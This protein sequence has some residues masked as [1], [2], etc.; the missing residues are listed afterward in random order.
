MQ[1][2]D[3]NAGFEQNPAP[4][5]QKGRN[6]AALVLSI[7]SLATGIFSVGFCWAGYVGLPFGIAAI[8][9]G[10]IAKKKDSKSGMAK[11][12]LILGIIGS[13]LS[14]VFLVVLIVVIAEGLA[15]GL[16]YGLDYWDM[17]MLA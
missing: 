4:Q 2:Q 14:L 11:A 3:Y 10:A 16:S 15:G 1:E 13:V 5:P 9:T 17:G 7:V 12:G 6:V 8:V